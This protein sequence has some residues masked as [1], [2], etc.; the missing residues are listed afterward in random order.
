MCLL[1]NKNF[2]IRD[3]KNKKKRKQDHFELGKADD[4]D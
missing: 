1:I 3:E 4:G 2:P